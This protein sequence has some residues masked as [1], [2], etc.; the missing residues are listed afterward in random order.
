MSPHWSWNTN[1]I[2]S[3]HRKQSFLTMRRILICRSE[4]NKTL[5]NNLRC[6]PQSFAHGDTLLP[7]HLTKREKVAKDIL[8]NRVKHI[9]ESSDKTGDT[10]LHVISTAKDPRSARGQLYSGSPPRSTC[11]LLYGYSRG[12]CTTAAPTE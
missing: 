12:V 10:A 11:K 8:C 1:I 6:L 5:Q 4:T 7:L 2:K 9:L 3:R